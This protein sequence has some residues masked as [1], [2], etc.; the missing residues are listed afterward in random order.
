M[1]ELYYG[2]YK[3]LSYKDLIYISIAEV[4][5]MGIGI[6]NDNKLHVKNTGFLKKSELKILDKVYLNNN[7]QL[8][9]SELENW[10]GD[11]RDDLIKES[12]L[13]KCFFNNYKYT[14]IFKTKI[15]QCINN[16]FNST[17]I[18]FILSKNI[19]LLKPIINNIENIK[20]PNIIINT[21]KNTLIDYYNN[22]FIEIY[23]SSGR[24]GSNGRTYLLLQEIKRKFKK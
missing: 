14:K 21:K 1:R 10:F 16:K 8:F 20:I 11:I 22:E 19:E 13:Q 2:F 17:I 23:K 7:G 15:K 9:Q 24:Y 12:Y 18:K 3:E 5:L 6:F 4:I